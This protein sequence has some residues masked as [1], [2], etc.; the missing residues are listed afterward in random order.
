MTFGWEWDFEEIKEEKEKGAEVSFKY[1]GKGGL[2]L[3]LT[4]F[5]TYLVGKMFTLDFSKVKK[6]SISAEDWRD[7]VDSDID[8]PMVDVNKVKLKQ[9]FSPTEKENPQMCSIMHGEVILALSKYENKTDRELHAKT[10]HNIVPASDDDTPCALCGDIPCVWLGEL[11][12]IVA[13]DKLEHLH[14]F[15]VQNRTHR[16]V[17]FR[18]MFRIINGGAGQKDVRKRHPECVENGNRALFPDANYM[19]FKEER[20][21]CLE[22]AQHQN[23]GDDFGSLQLAL[24]LVTKVGMSE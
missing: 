6:G 16:R 8:F 22:G 7:E 24:N 3:G 23:Y 4:Y 18:Y 9:G 1:W 19:G 12:N 15:S 21:I 14:T 2:E 11:G 10:E 13:N 5:G 17:A 20:K